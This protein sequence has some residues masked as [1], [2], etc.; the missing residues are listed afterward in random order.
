MIRFYLAWLPRF[1]MGVLVVGFAGGCGDDGTCVVDEDCVGSS[2]VCSVE[3]KCQAPDAAID[4]GVG[5]ANAPDARLQDSAPDVREP[6]DSSL[7]S[8]DVVP[9]A[10]MADGDVVLDAQPVDGSVDSNPADAVVTPDG[11]MMM[12]DSALVDAAGQDAGPLDAGGD[13]TLDASLPIDSGADSAVDS[14]V[15]TDATADATSDAGPVDATA[16]GSP[17][18]GTT[19]SGTTD[20]GTTDSGTTDA[21]ISASLLRGLGGPLGFGTG[22]IGAGDDNASDP[23]SLTTVFPTGLNFYGAS[24]NTI[25]MNTNGV[26]TFSGPLTTFT[27][28]IPSSAEPLIAP[29]WADVDTRP[30]G[31]PIMNN[32]NWHMDAARL[33]FT[34]HNVGYFNRHTDLLNSFQA[35]ITERSDIAPGD[36]DVE[37]RYA[38]CEWTTGDASGGTGG[39]GGTEAGA[40][41][42]NGSGTS[43]VLPGSHM[44][45][46]IDLCQNSNVGSPGI[47]Q[48]QFRSGTPL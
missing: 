20:S 43:L 28:D 35:I 47:W 41:F 17:D 29:F 2:E 15:P 39:L 13:A 10:A 22:E 9:D 36:F 3:G 18:S 26:L 25:H 33:V 6:A 37:F 32:V 30:D 5:D 23:I 27:P 46:V 38:R 11:F 42:T 4:G 34:W 7:D 14:A 45:E 44:P 1:A 8:G 31:R 16:D 48:Y 12:V 24:W 40:G 21:G 19:D